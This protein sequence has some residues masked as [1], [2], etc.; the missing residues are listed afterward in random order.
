MCANPDWR[1]VKT[2]SRLEML[3]DPRANTR[4][5]KDALML[6]YLDGGG[7]GCNYPD[8][9]F[10]MVRRWFHHFVFYGFLLCFAAT[11]VA[12]SKVL[13]PRAREARSV[14]PTEL[15]RMGATVD[16]VTAYETRQADNSGEELI[17]RLTDGTIDMVTFTSSSTVKNF[18]RLLPPDRADRLMQGVTVA[19]IGPITT[20]TAST[21]GFH[22]D[23][24]AEE[25]TIPGLSS[26][27]VEFYGEKAPE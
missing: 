7:Y 11:A 6:R 5:L 23:L 1:K 2:V 16:E 25:Y 21:L 15:T 4:A 19:S 3:L 8:D 18:H 22:V 20:E 12:G 24:N 26:A 10:S 13:L 17:E 27:I 9:R 14:L